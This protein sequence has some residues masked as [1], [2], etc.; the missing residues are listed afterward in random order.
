M[1]I[2][3]KT[4]DRN[5]INVHHGT[6]DSCSSLPPIPD[7]GGAGELSLS[8][9][10][11][12]CAPVVCHL[13]GS[14]LCVMGSVIWWQRHTEESSIRNL[15]FTELLSWCNTLTVGFAPVL[16]DLTWKAFIVAESLAFK[17]TRVFIINV[18]YSVQLSGILGL[19]LSIY[20]GRLRVFTWLPL[21]WFLGPTKTGCI[22]KHSA[23]VGQ[24]RN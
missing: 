15:G 19:S 10:A 13:C 14:R 17:P 24:N 12:I 5:Y 21:I 2:W 8:D 1:N 20:V 22:S 3:I 9:V 11:W 7:L 23:S 6:D 16:P 4:Q 18:S